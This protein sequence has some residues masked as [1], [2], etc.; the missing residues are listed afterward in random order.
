MTASSSLSSQTISLGSAAA[1]V[2]V[3]VVL[4]AAGAP[5]WVVVAL[6][7][8]ALVSL[9][10]TLLAN[11][12]LRHRLTQA[13]DVMVAL[14]KG[15][16]ERRLNDVEEKGLLGEVLWAVNDLAD[17]TD[18]FVRESGASLHAVIEQR[19]YRRVMEEGMAGEFRRTAREINAATAGMGA[20]VT[21]AGDATR[22]FEAIAGEVIAKVTTASTALEETATTLNHAT[23]VTNSRSV[24]VA[25]AS[26]Q[27]SVSLQSVASATEELTASIDEIN[28]QVQSSVQVAEKLVARTNQAGKDVSR[29]VGSAAKIGEVVTLI[30]DIAAQTNLLALNA[31]IE[32]ARAGEA[33]KGFAVVASEVKNLANQSAQAT[34]EIVAQVEAIRTS[35]DTVS[36][37]IGETEAVIKEMTGAST[38][39]AGAMEQQAAAT[40]EIARN[41]E[42]A[43]S[44]AAEVVSNISG[45]REAAAATESSAGV[46]VD[47]IGSLKHQ[48]ANFNGEL[49]KFLGE[50]K[51][52]I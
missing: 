5:V 17:R 40:K 13:L 16:F 27:A 2:V 46:L 36:A 29:L 19:Y 35:V 23:T 45:V 1:L 9:S 44:G 43:S 11:F 39:I 3:S 38:A 50:L 37:T 32:A 14:Q 26:E 25:A 22:R 47:S 18:S 34:D 52:V 8:A 49:A 41:V 20:K 48:S 30:R 51:R 33:G 4:I 31:T 15:D 10:L 28:R 24:A 21:E 6:L 12:R 42:H 7:G